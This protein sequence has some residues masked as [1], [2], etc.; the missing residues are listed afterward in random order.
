[1]TA[2]S[3]ISNTQYV[4]DALKYINGA[5]VTHSSIV[6][7]AAGAIGAVP[8]NAA[9]MG[10]FYTL[11]RV[12]KGTDKEMFS[13]FGHKFHTPAGITGKF[14]LVDTTRNMFNVMTDT[15]ITSLLTK[16]KGLEGAVQN[17]EIIDAVKT[18][19]KSK[20]PD[21]I[22]TII[23]KAKSSGDDV[24]KALQKEAGTVAKDGFVSK[25]VKQFTGWVASKIPTAAKDW[26]KTN[27][28]GIKLGSKTVGE[29]AKTGTSKFSKAFNT[30]GG[31]FI[32][33]LEGISALFT[34]VVPAFSEG[35]IGEGLKQTG[36]SAA[37]VGASAVG[38]TVGATLG[39]AAFTTLGTL[40]GG[41]V[42][43]F[44]GGA[45]GTFIGDMVGGTIG[46]AIAGKITEKVVGEDYTD[47][48][49]NEQIA[50]QAMMIMQDSS[51]MNELN[52][53]VFAMV[54][55]D[56]ADDGKLTKDSKKM[57]QYL[58][59]GAGNVSTYSNVSFLGNSQVQNQA[60]MN[61]YQTTQTANDLNT[62]VA[63]IQ[64][65]DT[66]VYDV[67]N[68]VLNASAKSSYTSTQSGF[69]NNYT[70]FGYQNPYA[71]T[72][73]GQGTVYNYYAEA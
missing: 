2:V 73:M 28:G 59:S 12:F 15:K 67:P 36:K 68:E 13:I 55:Q 27:I 40:I 49:Q 4:S 33:A 54:Q 69:A 57:L 9:L 14:G 50:N 1:M 47:K 7:D 39:K 64:A 24:V 60:V 46:S 18:L 37:K 72:G 30:S 5:E 6:D 16:G 26:V 35:G 45:I 17:T 53:T 8:F 43:G 21:E 32:V 3:S 31:G 52:Q 10:S 19:S 44:I 70:N 34:D 42:G 25:R 71:P 62:L 41:P 61:P 66:S 63:R 56:M 29:L 20:R 58:E 51:T 22:K 48:V 65:G 11:G 23:N 38:W